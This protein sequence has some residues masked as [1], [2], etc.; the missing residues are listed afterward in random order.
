M[1]SSLVF[2]MALVNFI[3]YKAFAG[4]PDDPEH[5]RCC[6][7][8]H[9]R[10]KKLERIRCDAKT[11]IRG[12]ICCI[13]VGRA[14]YFCESSDLSNQSSCQEECEENHQRVNDPSQDRLL[15]LRNFSYGDEEP[16]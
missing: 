10:N 9:A 2:G 3:M 8:K 16:Y 12:K 4:H 11:P 7:C 6:C 15:L 5:N 1:I 14:E 13:L